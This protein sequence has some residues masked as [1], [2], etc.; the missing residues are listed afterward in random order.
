MFPSHDPS[1]IDLQ[2]AYE[3]GNVITTASVD[4]PLFVSGTEEIKLNGGFGTTGL[5]TFD[6]NV[7]DPGSASLNISCANFGAGSASINIASDDAVTMQTTEG[8]ITVSAVDGFAQLSSTSN[9]ELIDAYVAIAASNTADGYASIDIT[10]G[11][12]INIT[13]IDGYSIVTGKHHL[14]H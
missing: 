12:N 8:D 11:N 5:S 3:N 9:D 14:L 2:G 13:T 1:A 6:V 7:N 4:G 10:A